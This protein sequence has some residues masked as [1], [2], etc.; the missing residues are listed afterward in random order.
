MEVITPITRLSSSG[1]V[2]EFIDD[3]QFNWGF[4]SV[5][6]CGP[7][8]VSLFFHSLPP[9]QHNPYI[10][11]QVHRMASDDYT[12]FIG[13]DIP[14]D[15]AGT[16]D[17]TLYTLLSYHGFHYLI[18]PND[19]SV[20]YRI[21]AWLRCGYPVIC[22][23]FENSVIDRELGKCPYPWPV[24][25]MTHII[26]ATGLVDDSSQFLKFRDTAN[27]INNGDPNELR[28]G[29]REYDISKLKL[30]SATVVVP[31]W[32]EV[33]PVGFDPRPLFPSP[34]PTG[35]ISLEEQLLWKSIDNIPLNPQAAI[36][37]DWHNA[38][39]NG[40]YYGPPISNEH[41][42]NGKTV[43]YFT[44]AKAEW[45]PGHTTKWYAAM[46]TLTN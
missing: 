45:E 8:S 34:T 27:V 31:S 6:K 18:L 33:P 1:E 7:E 13:P 16:S 19:D 36:F 32:L 12:R 4:E 3:N 2:A 24:G 9:G 14:T 25:D 5:M 30:T 26:L 37:K 17:N 41:S 38:L 42:V 46:G 23:M 39:N 20:F 28:P 21:K 11:A 10:S 44:N 15:K 35:D 43:Q 29:P 40:K 22:G